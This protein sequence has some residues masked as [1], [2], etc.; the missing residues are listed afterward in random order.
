MPKF[1]IDCHVGLNCT[2]DSF[3]FHSKSSHRD[4]LFNI[5]NMQFKT[6]D[7]IYGKQ[8]LCKC[9]QKDQDKSFPECSYCPSSI[10]ISSQSHTPY[11]QNHFFSENFGTI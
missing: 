5:L 9:M 11:M 7:S 10:I 4:P 1:I 2:E 6:Y 3:S 8:D